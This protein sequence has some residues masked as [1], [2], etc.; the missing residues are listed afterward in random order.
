MGKKCHFFAKKKPK[1]FLGVKRWTV[2]SPQKNNLKVFFIKKRTIMKIRM[3]FN[4]PY[5]TLGRQLQI[6]ARVLDA[7]LAPGITKKLEHL[8]NDPSINL[9]SLIDAVEQVFKLP[10]EYPKVCSGSIGS[11]YNICEEFIQQLKEDFFVIN[12]KNING[13]PPETFPNRN[14]LYKSFIPFICG[15]IYAF[16]KELFKDD[17]FANEILLTENPLQYGLNVIS[18]KCPQ[19]ID[20]FHNTKRDKV[21]RWIAGKQ[22]P[23]MGNLFDVINKAKDVLGNHYIQCCEIAFVSQLLQKTTE[24][25]K[26]VYKIQDYFKSLIE[27]SSSNKN[28]FKDD[29][30]HLGKC[31][32]LQK[33]F[34]CAQ[35]GIRYCAQ[36]NPPTTILALNQF[37]KVCATLQIN[38]IAVE[39][40]FN[41]LWVLSLIYE[42]KFD[43]ALETLKTVMPNLFYTTDI[44]RSAIYVI[45]PEKKT[46]CSFFRVARDLG[47]ICGDRPFL[48]MMQTYAIVFGLSGKPMDIHRD[49][50]NNIPYVNKSSR[51]HDNIV[52]DWEVEQ[53]ANDFFILFSEKDVKNIESIKDKK[54]DVHLPLFFEEGKIPKIPVKPYKT[55]FEISWKTYPQLVW[56]TQMSDVDAVKTLL[57]AN[58][59]VNA[60]SSS[61]ESAL[62]FAIESMVYNTIPFKPKEGKEIFHLIVSHPHDRKTLLTPT[63]KK[64]LTCLGQAILTGEVDVVQKLIE[65]G[66]DVNQIQS[67]D[68]QSPLYRAVQY[69]SMP[70]II[71]YHQ[72]PRSWTPEMLDGIRRGNEFF[73][74]MTNEEVYQSMRL[75]KENPMLEQAKQWTAQYFEEQ[76]KK[77]LS[78][79][80]MFSI[81]K[82]L[83]ENGAD[84]NQR[85]DVNGLIGYTP[86][87][88]A[89]EK[90]LIDLF[91]L[92]IKH[93]GN[94]N[95]TARDTGPYSSTISCWEIA[96]SWKSNSILKY[97]EENRDQFK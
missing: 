88:M 56:F 7:D 94:P 16:V 3:K 26:P 92:M 35:D 58:V 78:K 30:I 50:Y 96:Y 53:W 73:R 44:I 74:N 5:P 49:S 22:L 43:E 57:D 59:D 6:V 34:I 64:K 72:N 40:R 89:A 55:P 38:S 81:A 93:G 14:E 9:Y 31:S 85:H 61:G 77:Y 87:M 62:L 29:E 48:K 97:L 68:Q 23:N 47:A 63:N 18:E 39:W 90:N 45:D 25:A 46:S 67:T 60:L 86:L 69:S 41:L 80:K 75:Q 66:A 33:H 84:P 71:D 83:L 20:R 82:I 10:F 15:M 13:W 70:N 2:Q 79:E 36:Q 42:G 17:N 54:T 27:K 32:I 95:Q 11:T 52:E 8:A 91:E 24:I 76:W 65:M 12:Q 1:H 51:S 19:L 28:E 4:P 21:Q 37:A